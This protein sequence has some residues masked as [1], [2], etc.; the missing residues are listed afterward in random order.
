M[1][2]IYNKLVRDNIPEIIAKNG[3]TPV[4]YKITDD[5]K[6]RELLINKLREEVE[7]YCESLNHEEL[8]DIL[9]VIRCLIKEIHHRKYSDIENIREFKKNE[10]GGF[11][12]R[13]FLERVIE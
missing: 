9:E 3:S 8:A 1:I 10:I 12:D 2:K 7:E 5:N 11:K 6:L 13:V 4:S